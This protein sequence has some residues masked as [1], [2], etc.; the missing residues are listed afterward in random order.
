MST[1]TASRTATVPRTTPSR[2]PVPRTRDATT[3]SRLR[4]LASVARRS[5]PCIV[6]EVAKH[7]LPVWPVVGFVILPDLAFLVCGRRGP[8][9][10]GAARPPRGARLQPRAPAVAAPGPDRAGVVRRGPA[11]LLRGW[12]GVAAAHR[13]RPR[14]W[15]RPAHRRRVAACL[16]NHRRG[17]TRSWPRRGPSWRREGPTRSRCA[18]SPSGSA[19]ALPSLYKHVPD[20]AAL[21]A[22]I[23]ADAFVEQ[24]AVF[25]ACRRPRR[26]SARRARRRVPRGG[27][28]R[29]RTSTRL[30]TAH[31]LAR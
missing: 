4:W 17:S 9:R 1:A 5:S 15:L 21:E 6:F 24:A 12:V 31:P 30:M 8:D 23:I 10:A 2:S 11:H 25:A 18:P 22:A 16:S 27:R 7:D 29:I 19:S 26:R 28:S 13:P 14:E 3:A 20:K